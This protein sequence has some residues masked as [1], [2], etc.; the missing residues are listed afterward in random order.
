MK[1]IFILLSLFCIFINPCQAKLSNVDYTVFE[2]NKYFGLK[3]SEGTETVKAKYSKLIRL[4]DSS[5]IAQRHGK[6]GIID[7]FGNV[8]VPIKYK[9]ADRLLG[10]YLKLGG[11]S[12]YGIFNEKGEVIIP[13][14]YYSI[15]LL[16]G[17]MFLT[18]KNYKYGISDMKGN[19]ILENKFDNIYM[20]KPYIMRIQYNG[21]W[22]QIENKRGEEFCLPENIKDLEDDTNFTISD[23]V[24]EPIAASG[25]SAVTFTDYILKIISSISPAHEATIDEMILSQGADTVSILKKMTWIPMYPVIF[26]KKYYYD[27]RTPNNGPLNEYKDSLKV[28]MKEE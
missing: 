20:P 10:K 26:A 28:K 14:E 15:D 18:N 21:K 16:F 2:N 23:F 25:Y 1:K 7:S 24:N 22:Y 8:L 11:D 9:H 19:V 12:K 13:M 4:G 27:F 6:Y 3:N 17:G 5:W